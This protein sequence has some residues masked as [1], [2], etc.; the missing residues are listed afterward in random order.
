NAGKSSLFNLLTGKKQLE[1]DELFATLDS[2]VGK[3]YLPA[4]HHDVLVTDTIGF[5][6][7]L[8]PRLVQAFTSTLME[9][10]HADLLL[11]IVD[12]GDPEISVKVQVVNTI[13]K[14]IGR[15][16]G[17]VVYVFNKSDSVDASKKEE[18]QTE[19]RQLEP[20]FVSAKTGDGIE[21]VLETIAARLAG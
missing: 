4:L 11:H 12:A 18:L 19:Y 5:I 2:S 6:R 3:L 15:D 10:V 17:D 13:L 16:T 21:T 20:V 9:S 14:D 7:N 1:K 8:P